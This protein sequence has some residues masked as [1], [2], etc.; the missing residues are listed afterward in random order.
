MELAEGVVVRGWTIERKLGAGSFGEVWS[1]IDTAT[2]LRVAIKAMRKGT[3]G[4][5]V[6]RFKREAAGLKRVQSDY[7]GRFIDFIVEG[8][9]LLLI[10][11]YV[12]GELLSDVLFDT[13]L[14]L[15][16]TLEL[17]IHLARGLVDLH[18]AGV[19]HRD[20][21]PSNIILRP[22]ESGM[23]RAVILDLGLSRFLPATD[24]AAD[25]ISTNEVTA[26]AS[27]VAIG[28]PG[29]MAP[30]QILDARKAVETSDIYGLGMVL[31]R[32][33]AGRLPFT[34]TDIEIVRKKLLEEAPALD[35]GRRDVS[36]KQFGDLVAKCI[37]KRAEE[38]YI[39]AQTV[40]D[41]LIILRDRLQLEPVRSMSPYPGPPSMPAP[42]LSSSFPPPAARSEQAARDHARNIENRGLGTF[43]F[44]VVGALVIVGILAALA[45]FA[46]S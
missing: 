6:G 46:L 1:A 5:L 3:G 43:A 11:E 14:G 9:D 44:F 13:N 37:R 22:L 10:M 32:A 4:D 8:P 28:T 18:A 41:E 23:Q 30:E 21:K 27:K 40:L 17:G 45:F 29:F 7:V 39:Q 31:Y 33:I 25:D 15:T 42:P 12:E 35:L 38:R 20:I 2:G 34:G 19:I 36:S 26:T 16:E 24:S